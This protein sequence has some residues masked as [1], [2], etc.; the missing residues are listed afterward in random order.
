MKKEIYQKVTEL[1]IEKIALL[2][3][4]I[5]DTKNSMFSETKSSMGDK[6]ETARAMTQIELDNEYQQLHETLQQKELLLTINPNQTNQRVSLGSLVTTNQGVFYI[7]TGIGKVQ[8]HDGSICFVISEQ[9]P[10]AQVLKNKKR[11]DEVLFNAQ[12]IHIQEVE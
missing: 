4:V 3:N 12:L 8:L 9:S 7:A 1:I 2:Q 6:H 10:V 11:G 5:D